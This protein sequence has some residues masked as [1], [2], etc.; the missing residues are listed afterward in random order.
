MALG[1]QAQSIV[2][3][4]IRQGLGLT[5]AGTLLGIAG[6]IALTRL[7]GALLYATSPTDAITFACVSLLFLLVAAVACFIPARQVTLI[8]PVIALRQE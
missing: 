4:V 5:I 8:D 1:A 2:R 7:L 3:M 6:A